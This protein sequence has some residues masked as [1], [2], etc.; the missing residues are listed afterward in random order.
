MVEHL[1]KVRL[2]RS[3]LEVTPLCIGGGPISSM[4]DV[5]GYEVPTERALQTIRTALA[6]PI[7][8]IDTAAGCGDGS[9]EAMIGIVLGELG[10]VPDGY[11]VATKADRDLKTGDFSGVQVRR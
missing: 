7:N 2:T 5:F 8:W 11:V 6:S 1:P 4:P 3:G 9:V 10:G